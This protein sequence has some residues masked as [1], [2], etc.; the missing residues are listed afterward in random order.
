[1]SSKLRKQ[2]KLP[3][4]VK[5]TKSERTFR[6]MK[7]PKYEWSPPDEGFQWGCKLTCSQCQAPTKTISGDQCRNRTCRY[8]PYC[9]LHNASLLNIKVKPSQFLKSINVNKNN[10]GL[11]AWSPYKKGIVFKKNQIIGTYWGERLS[12]KAIDNRY[13]TS[14]EIRTAPYGLTTTRQTY[15]DAGK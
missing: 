9:H 2:I 11:H 13:D 5:Q 1:L 8:F 12:S 10:L 15:L 6:R 3:N 7:P 14:N 4:N